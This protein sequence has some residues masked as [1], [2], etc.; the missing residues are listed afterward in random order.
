MLNFDMVGR[1]NENKDLAINGTG[2]SSKWQTLINEVNVDE[3]FF[4]EII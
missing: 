4:F 1:L 2:T 3:N